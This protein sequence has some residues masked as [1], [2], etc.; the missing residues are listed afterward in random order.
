MSETMSQTPKRFSLQELE[1]LKAKAKALD[2]AVEYLAGQAD[3]EKL[4]TVSRMLRKW[5]TQ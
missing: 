4:M 1:I 2:E 3:S 5:Q